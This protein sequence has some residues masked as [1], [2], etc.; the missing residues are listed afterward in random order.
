[1]KG[2]FY[3]LGL[4]L[5]AVVAVGYLFGAVV[6]PGQMGVRQI[7]FGPYRGFSKEALPAGYHWRVPVYSTI[8]MVP[9]TVNILNLGTEGTQGGGAIEV[10]T[11]DGSSVEV[12][13][14]IFTRF[15]PSGG[16]DR[17]GPSELI[18]KLGTRSSLWTDRIRTA[19]INEIRKHLGRLSTSEFYNPHLREAAVQDA[20]ESLNGRL[21]NFGVKVESI[22]LRRYTYTEERIDTAIFQKNLQDQEERLNTAKKFLAEAKADLEKVSAEWD[23]KIVTLRT[24]GENEVRVVRS[25]ADLYE[26]EKKAEGD[27]MVAKAR[28]E[29]DRLK[30]G[31]LASS[32]GAD[33]F[34]GKS[35]AP[36]LASLKG[37]LVTELDPY[38]LKEWAAKLGVKEGS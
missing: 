23:A 22:L 2:L 9:K 31:A 25:Q 6:P 28:A 3:L 8:H 27:L 18:Q 33:I 29:V 24:Q 10:Q 30:A 26:T 5:L 34:V 32:V 36:L 1:M 21:N 15:F 35:L 7:A 20:L 37:G 12:D 4:L 16:E 11:T 38:N 14:S 13:V 17:G 19:G